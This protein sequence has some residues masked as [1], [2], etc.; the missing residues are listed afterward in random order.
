MRG[1]D[2]GA[3]DEL[4]FAWAGHRRKRPGGRGCKRRC[5]LVLSGLP[6][7][8]GSAVPCMPSRAPIRTSTKCL[9]F[10]VV[11]RELASCGHWACWG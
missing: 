11:V 5:E 2:V 9:V 4:E 1:R 6:L 10:V 3:A 7:H 8:G